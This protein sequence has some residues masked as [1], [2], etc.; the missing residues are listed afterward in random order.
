MPLLQ[1]VRDAF[2]DMPDSELA[3]SA[4][5][6]A[7]DGNVARNPRTA[8]GP[9]SRLTIVGRSELRGEAKLRAAL[10]IF[11]VSPAGRV[12]LDAGA[13]AGGFTRVLLDQGAVR[14]YAVDAGHGQL[15]G[16]LRQDARTV[17][18]EATNLGVLT[19]VIVP[20]EVE[21]VTLDLS[22]LSLADA[23]PQLDRIAI[24]P[25]AD[26]IALVKPMFELHLSRPPVD[27]ALLR[28]ACEAACTGIATAGWRVVHAVRSPMK[29]ARGA[30]EFLVHAR[31]PR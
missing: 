3:I 5:T 17:N 21:L 19:R 6:I 25:G 22:Y 16:S 13:A 11:G 29:G 26:L 24:A 10:H 18:L 31:Y 9:G 14:V 8:V 15:L 30:V 28:A 23:V 7:V 12:A 20:D 4:G 2:P 27:E 1:A